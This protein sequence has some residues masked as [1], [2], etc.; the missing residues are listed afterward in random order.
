MVGIE[1][2]LASVALTG[3]ATALNPARRA[4][5]NC[6]NGLQLPGLIAENDTTIGGI[7]DENSFPR[8]SCSISGRIQK[9]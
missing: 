5:E 6:C 9:C 4:S 3:R 7:S 2:I 1:H 8:T